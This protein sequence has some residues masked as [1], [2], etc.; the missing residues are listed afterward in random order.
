MEAWVIVMC[1]QWRI[2]HR[3]IVMVSARKIYRWCLEIE[4]PV[5]FYG[6]NETRWMCFTTN[7]KLRAITYSYPEVWNNTHSN[8]MIP[9]P[10]IPIQRLVEYSYPVNTPC[11]PFGHNWLTNTPVWQDRA[12][13]IHWGSTQTSSILKNAPLSPIA[14]IESIW[15]Q[16]IP[17]IMHNPVCMRYH[18]SF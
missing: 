7:L 14:P 12:I 1:M 5:F 6:N 11:Y 3:P 8:Q 16:K 4:L 18:K 2:V 13:D 15:L 10:C 17:G 9:S